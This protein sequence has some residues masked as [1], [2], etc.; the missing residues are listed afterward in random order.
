MWYAPRVSPPRDFVGRWENFSSDRAAPASART[1]DPASG[2]LNVREKPHRQA[3]PMRSEP[4]SFS[5][6]TNP[7]QPPS[8]RQTV[9][10][11]RAFGCVLAEITNRAMRFFDTAHP[12]R[13]EGSLV[14]LPDS[15]STGD[16][17]QD[18][19][20]RAASL[21]EFEYPLVPNNHASSCALSFDELKEPLDLLR[22]PAL[23][24]PVRKRDEKAI[25]TEPSSGNRRPSCFG[26]R[27]DDTP[28]PP[29]APPS[30]EVLKCLY[31]R[32]M[33]RRDRCYLFDKP[34]L[35]RGVRLFRPLA[36]LQGL[37]MLPLA[38]ATG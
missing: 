10:L 30:I 34:R 15:V 37:Q 38:I 13:P 3:S 24:V 2:R 11:S 31:Y 4:F 23:R 28:H 7:E 35:H 18:V 21:R 9:L 16:P 6:T 20:V 33:V 8:P 12:V 17:E 14:W 1:P 5:T 36:L 29:D 22:I 26:T 27:D 32:K 25:C 19:I